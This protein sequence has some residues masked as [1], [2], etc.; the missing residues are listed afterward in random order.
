MAKDTIL[1]RLK[2]VIKERVVDGK[3]RRPLKRVNIDITPGEFISIVDER[4]IVRDMVFGILGLIEAPT[5]GTVYLLS[6]EVSGLPEGA[7]TRLRLGHLGLVL[8]DNIFIDELT[9]KENIEIFLKEAGV[10]RK[11]REKRAFVALEMVGLQDKADFRPMELSKYEV[12]AA[13]IA[14]AMANRPD[15]LIVNEPSIEVDGRGVSMMDLLKDLHGR[16]GVTVVVITTDER[17]GNEA[18]TVYLLRS[19]KMTRSK[20]SKGSKGPTGSKGYKRPR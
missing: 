14:R 10:P 17:L 4:A 2:D 13:S 8:K 18:D 1:M 11:E 5:S 3:R 16:T 15:L 12:K 19:G 6:K 7:L 9:I 20:G